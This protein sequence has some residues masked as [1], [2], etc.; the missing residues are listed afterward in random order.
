MLKIWGRPPHPGGGFDTNSLLENISPENPI[1]SSLLAPQNPIFRRLRRA[2]Q[3]Y[4]F[5]GTE[6]YKLHITK[7]FP[8]EVQQSLVN[9][10]NVTDVRFPLN[11]QGL[12]ARL[13]LHYCLDGTHGSKKLGASTLKNSELLVELHW[14]NGFKFRES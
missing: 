4:S 10:F 14:W 8:Y 11:L 7:P 2:S 9:D 13:Y 3:E 5:I 1:L 12:A 6:I